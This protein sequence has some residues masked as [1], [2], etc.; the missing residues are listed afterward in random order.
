LANRTER[1]KDQLRHAS[2][3]KG[4]ITVIGAINQDITIFEKTFGNSGE[5]VP[6]EE[7]REYPGGKGANVA[8]AASKIQGEA[9]VAFVGA[10]GNDAIG[11]ALLDDLRS[12]GVNVAGAARLKGARTGRAFIIVDA[13]GRKIIHV[14]FG[15]NDAMD[16]SHLDS[17]YAAA[18]ISSSSVVIVMDPPTAVAL[19]AATISKNAGAR[20]VYSP[21]ARSLEGGLL[22]PVLRKANDLVLDKSELTNL[23][24]KEDPLAALRYLCSKHPHLTILATMGPDGSL[25]SVGGKTSKIEPVKLS[26]MQLK[27]VNSTGS[28][29]AFLAAYVCYSMS[30]ANPSEAARWGNLAGALKAARA[31]TRGSPTGK[32]LEEKMAELDAVKE[33]RPASRSSRA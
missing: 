27:A 23:A 14:Y 11:S 15:A 1:G 30:G 4:I 3:A 22:E 21:G 33:R 5:E 16:P 20:V 7:V 25:V 28:G 18:A 31:E 6:V 2:R 26:D 17:Q 9:G 19:K 29:D 24:G 8:V 10:V 13:E 12:A 32:L